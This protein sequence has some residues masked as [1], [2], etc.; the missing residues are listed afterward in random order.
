MYSCPHSSSGSWLLRELDNL[1]FLPLVPKSSVMRPESQLKP[2]NR[3]IF[4][5]ITD[6]LVT[7]FQRSLCNRR[8]RRIKRPDGSWSLKEQNISTLSFTFKT[9]FRTKLCVDWNVLLVGHVM[10]GGSKT[11]TPTTGD[12]FWP[13]V[14]SAY[15]KVVMVVLSWLDSLLLI[16]LVGAGEM[17]PVILVLLSLSG[18]CLQSEHQGWTGG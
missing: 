12:W 18:L 14:D 15:L 5:M 9:S 7:P 16:W 1:V 2:Y 6:W 13:E 3:Y 4:N 10:W 8:Q 17:F 11:T